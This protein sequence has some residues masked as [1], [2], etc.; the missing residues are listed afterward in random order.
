MLE[1]IK[2]SDREKIGV[3]AITNINNNKKYIGSTKESFYR[4]I[5]K[6]LSL[7]KRN[8]HHSIKLQNAYNKYGIS[9]FSFS[10]IEE[11]DKNR[12]DLN[13]YTEEREQYYI[14]LNESFLQEKG[15]NILNKAY[16][17]PLTEI[18]QYKIECPDKSVVII[19]NLSEF[20]RN[21]NLAQTFYKNANGYY[22][23]KGV[24]YKAKSE[25]KGFKI[26]ERLD[27]EGKPVNKIFNYSKTQESN[28]PFYWI[29]LKENGNIIAE[30]YDL[31]EYCEE[32]NLNYYT[33]KTHKQFKLNVFEC[34]WKN[35]TNG[36]VD[37][38]SELLNRQNQIRENKE[39]ELQRKLIN[40]DKL[41]E[42]NKGKKH[43][44]E[45]KLKIG[46]ASLGR[47]HTE[48][49]KQK[50]REINI[51]LKRTGQNCINI[52]ISKSQK[53]YIAISPNGIK[54]EVKVL[55][56]FCKEHNIN[57]DKMRRVA[58]GLENYHNGWLCFN[59]L[60]FIEKDYTEELKKAKECKK[61][62]NYIITTPDKIKVVL[63][64]DTLKE[65]CKENNLIHKSLI[66]TANPKRNAKSHRGY[67]ASL[68]Q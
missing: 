31:K 46:L 39:K 9:N 17:T 61:V 14:D 30:I 23:R 33:I 5:Q 43:S 6:H 37:I 64:S 67:S 26:L 18:Y 12:L 44:K 65:Y 10:I 58:N 19:K 8:K 20:C 2:R 15:Y 11:I 35:Y 68:I 50:L 32:N 1:T 56:L 13:K 47:T 16:A 63:S 52:A 51:G 55:S 59:K 4:R 53:E 24:L 41:S 36:N 27:L 66:E 40:I 57:S 29:H 48:E 54:Y 49:T 28:S 3:Y 22:V 7:L 62:K 45:H 38:Y 25:Y 34:I 60:E 42:A 21:N